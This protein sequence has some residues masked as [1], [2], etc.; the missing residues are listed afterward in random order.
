MGRMTDSAHVHPSSGLSE[1]AL[2]LALFAKYS[3]LATYG[4]WAAVVEIPTFVIVGSPIFAVSWALCVA[5]FAIVAAAG[6]AR[7][8][9]TGHHRLERFSTAAFVLSFTAY[10]FA[11]IYR[12]WTSGEWTSAPLALIPLVVCILPTIRYYS[13]VLRARKG[14]EPKPVAA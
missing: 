12:S 8:W 14:R 10:S 2:S 6:V 9:T 4:V 1:R 5:I 11:L 3:G 13:L 7:T